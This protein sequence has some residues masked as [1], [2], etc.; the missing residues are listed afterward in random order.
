MIEVGEIVR[1][2]K[3]D[4]MA[5]YLMADDH[6]GLIINSDGTIEVFEYDPTEPDW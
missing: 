2:R 1:G 5:L 3:T 6:Y 4:V